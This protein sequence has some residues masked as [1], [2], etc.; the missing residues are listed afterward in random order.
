MVPLL[1]CGVI[2]VP[3]TASGQTAAAPPAPR[4]EPT[5]LGDVIVTARSLDTGEGRALPVQIISGDALAHRRQGGLGETLAGLP[6]VHLDSFGGGASRPVIRGQTV[7]RIEILTDGAQLFDAS[8][9]SPDHAITTDP[10][11]IDAIE[12]QRGPA[13]VRY[14][15]N[16]LNGAINL[17]DSKTPRAV[18][19]GGVA[20]ATEARYGTGDEE[21]TIVGRV[22]VGTGAFALHAEGAR[23]EAGDYAVPEA[24]GS[25]TLRDSFADSTSY[26][27]GA[28]WI[29]SK[30][31]VGAAYTRQESEYGLPGH[32]HANGVC[33]LHAPDLHCVAHGSITDPFAG[34]DDADVASIDLRSERVDIRADY[35][36]LLSGV[37]HARMR[38]SYT[39]YQHDEIDGGVLFSR[40]GNEVYDGRLELTHRPVA[41]FSGTFGVQ[42][43]DGTFSGLD[44]NN[45]HL[46]NRTNEYYTE[47]VGVFLN[48]QRAFGDVDVEL[49][50]RYDE[51]ENTAS[52]P[53]FEDAI[54]IP[55]EM[56]S[57]FDPSIQALLTEQYRVNYVIPDARHDLLS[58][59]ASA[60]WRLGGGAS[61]ALSLARSERAPG[62]R[63]LYAG[64]NNL[65]TNSFE[66]GLLRSGLLGSGFPT[67]ATDIKETANS[68][69]LTF[70]K[71]GGPLAFEV[72][73]FHQDVD[74][75]IFARFLE[76]ETDTGVPHRLLLYTA[77][78]ARFTGIDGQV[79]YQFDPA[80]RVTLFGDY[81]DASLKSASEN[82]PRIPP[83]RLGARYDF[84]GGPFSADFE[85]YHTFAQNDFA[86]YETRTAAYDM[87]N[88]TVG[89]RFDLVGLKGVE[90]YLRG[91][92]LLDELAF[93]HTS[94]VKD[95]SPLRGRS[96]AVGVRHRF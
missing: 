67:Y 57:L 55:L 17:I 23:R 24:Y 10:L 69:D 91:T 74:N 90:L 45:A 89:Y 79:S 54:G 82:L 88:A 48:E 12:I 8:S 21:R 41:G 76:E 86:A 34:I 7:P 4:D 84:V 27:V 71:V 43:T 94:F 63:E 66:V 47:A 96:V 1:A 75:Y 36:D 5:S 44:F 56:L 77:A 3:A 52:Y 28:S 31:Y 92:N 22:T 51:R 19:Q 49:A 85:I 53:S 46:I 65:A 2:L 6:G 81:V 30:G 83:G 95:Q 9:V 14:G 72:G 26:A 42:Y 59:S 35:D 20:G 37:E 87:V 32:S 16:A 58:V 93:A 11:L 18:P 33:H 73:L 64:G 50:A 15:G 25:D 13:A 39:D 38:L 60:N 70:R 68:A 29:T 40:Y 78:D 61:V 62:V 80:S